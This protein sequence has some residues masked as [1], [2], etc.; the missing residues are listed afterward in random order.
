MLI[1][2]Q[3]E[4]NHKKTFTCNTLFY[5]L[6]KFL[7]YGMTSVIIYLLVTLSEYCYNKYL[8]WLTGNLYATILIVFNGWPTMMNQ[9]PISSR[10]VKGRDSCSSCPDPFSEGSLKKKET[11]EMFKNQT[12]KVYM[13]YL[14]QY[15]LYIIHSSFMN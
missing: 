9:G 12:G 8:S 13:A 1:W 10:G 15:L 2:L 7:E 14:Q 11:K 3:F 4:S 5:K 6:N